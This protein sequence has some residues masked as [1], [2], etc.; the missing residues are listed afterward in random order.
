MNKKR[1]YRL[2]FLK[3]LK[4]PFALRNQLYNSHKKRKKN[5]G[6]VTIPFLLVIVIILFFT[7][8]FLMLSM[9]FVHVTVTQYLT[10]SSARKLS[11]GGLNETERIE[12]ARDHYRD[13]RAQFFNPNAHSGQEGDW[14]LIQ[15]ELKKG[16]QAYSTSG[17]Y[18]ESNKIV[19]RFYGINTEFRSNTLNL[20]I[21]FLIE[22]ADELIKRPVRVS[23][24]LGREPS[25]E[26][27]K[28]FHKE[29][30]RPKKMFEKMKDDCPP[31]K[32]PNMDS[33]DFKELVGDNGC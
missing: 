20:N 22:N 18:P 3:K 33:S 15:P 13:L 14:F 2:D 25:Q 26:E 29:E 10:Y 32:C 5:Q 12:S 23:S 27:C 28:N 6:I 21:P 7:L 24:F 1:I 8:A 16:K 30:Q 9:T 19:Q 11:L 17:V 4:K 31:N